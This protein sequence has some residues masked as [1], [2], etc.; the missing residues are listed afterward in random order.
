METVTQ[1]FPH[2]NPDVTLIIPQL[3]V[4]G[5]ALLLLLGDVLLD[6]SRHSV[7]TWLTLVGFGAALVANFFYIGVNR[8]TFNGMF[9]ADDISVFVNLIALTGA[10]LSVMIS[11]S[12]LE[13]NV[14]S[15]GMPLPE[16]YV[17]LA[18]STLGAMVVGAS[19]DLLMVFIGIEMGSL[20]IY[21]LTGFAR[22][23]MTS[24]EGALKY[25]L[26]G[27]FASAI[28]I[29]GM[30]WVYGAT[31][32]TNL[33]GVAQALSG[34]VTN[35]KVEPS[36]LLALLLLTVGLGF[37]VAAVPFHM[38]TPDAYQGAPTPVSAYMSV[39]PKIAGFAAMIRIFPQALGP[40]RDEWVTIIAILAIITMAFGNIVAVTQ[41]D[42]KRM[43]AY[44]SIGHTG[45][46]M[47]GL[48]AFGAVQASDDHS[49]SS[50]LYYLFA[51]AFMNIGAF[52]VV[53]WLQ[54]RGGG[55]TIDDFNGLGARSPLAAL[56]MTIFMFSLMGIPPLVGFY[57][58]YYVIVAT[59]EANMIWLAVS[60]VLASAVSAFFYLRVVAAMYF[61]PAPE[62]EMRE[63]RMPLM[64]TGLAVMVVAT[65]LA[66]IFSS[67]IL[68]L[69]QNWINAFSTTV[70]IR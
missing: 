31:G 10:I 44:S 62:T 37:K 66:G 12:Y 64:A 51:Y 35:G 53:A 57:A 56:S 22:K 5:T 17:L 28:L 6:R 43:L 61:A 65:I 47:A 38:W 1:L 2:I 34:V 16:Y 32:T 8:T 24:L 70:A 60:I 42:V 36:L 45:Y 13:K 41:R 46:V 11:A 40:M 63:S 15:G 50:V 27:L 20:A 21:A 33:D 9:R 67:Q 49:V 69:A 26:L 4:L 25:F 23:R 39:I 7:L 54:E 29:Y 19:G 55:T 59:I 3:I 68:N 48:A 14:E 18:L 52:A 30:A 58:K